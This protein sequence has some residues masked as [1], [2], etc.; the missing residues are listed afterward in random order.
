[1][2]NK[3]TVELGG[4]QA[5]ALLIRQAISESGVLGR[6]IARLCEVKPQ[7]VSNWKT[8]GRIEK[9]NLEKLAGITNKPLAFF[10]TLRKTPVKSAAG[11]YGP[12]V[13][14]EPHRAAE[15][16]ERYRASP[17]AAKAKPAGKAVKPSSESLELAA[18][19]QKLPA[20]QRR[21]IAQLVEQLAE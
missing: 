8:T 11:D 20:H 15:P 16:G 7:A 17:K 2:A 3:K 13:G 18:R 4:N 19:I 14:R 12:A 1:M 21:L 10:S 9:Q 6:E 5:L